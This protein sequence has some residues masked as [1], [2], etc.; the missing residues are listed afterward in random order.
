MRVLSS[1]YV[2]SGLLLAG[3]AFGLVPARAGIIVMVHGGA[4]QDCYIA[5]LHAPEQLPNAHA[6]EVCERAV[7]DTSIGERDRA[8]SAI[9]RAYLELRLGQYEAVLADSDRAIALMPSLAEGWLN[10][11]AALVG[12]ARYHE[13]VPALERSLAAGLGKQEAAYLDI[14]MAKEGLRDVRGAYENY[15]KAVDINPAFEMASDQLK[16]FTVVR[17]P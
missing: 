8:A 7:R 10:R 15:K 12:L 3:L 17:K 14:G 11:G 2:F 16:R 4:G 9:N 6:L 1:G 5:T 13:A